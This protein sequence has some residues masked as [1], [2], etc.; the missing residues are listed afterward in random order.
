VSF[1]KLVALA[2]SFAIR[3]PALAP[4][5][6]ATAWGVGVSVRRAPVLRR[7]GDLLVALDELDPVCSLISDTHVTGRGRVPT[8]LA[9]YPEQW[10][11]RTLPTSRDL[12]A[13][14]QRVLEHALRTG[15]RTV[16]WCGDEV[17]TGHLDEW[18]AWRAALAA[19]PG[20]THHIV[21]GNHDICFNRPFDEDY[22]LARRA[23]REEA[24][25]AHGP[26]LADYP[27]V[28][29]IAGDCGIVTVLLLDS[30]KHPSVHVLSNAIGRFGEA[31]LDEV[32]RILA[33]RTGPLLCITHH[34]VWRSDRFFD[35]EEWFNTAV[36]SDRLARILFAYRAR[37]PRNQ[38]LVCH[39]HRHIAAAGEIGD[40]D[41]AI[42]VMGLPSTTLGD[43]PDGVHLD[44]VVRHAVCGLRPDGR[45]GVAL[46][47]V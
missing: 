26:R 21:P 38:V 34:H 2:A 18:I 39:G 37:T 47:A 8:E 5:A 16:V 6:I 30:C 15:P 33:D 41:V 25:Q 19:T 27:L 4:P 9:L 28:D 3:R 7:R 32:E 43:K 10:P 22:T 45:W 24:F 14:L 11:G 40:G 13:R 36:D 12:T 35:V 42:D 46:V 20:L 44:G 17:D 29:T 1:G 23:A 31:Q